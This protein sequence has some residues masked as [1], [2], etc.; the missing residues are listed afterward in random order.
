MRRA[1]L[2]AVVQLTCATAAVLLLVQGLPSAQD[3]T[4]SALKAAYIYNFA[5]FTE[6]PAGVVL[7]A[8]PLALCVLGDTN[9]GDALKRAVKDRELGGHSMAVSQ[10]AMG[11]TGPQPTCH[12]M[13]VSGVSA[14]QAAEVIARV[15]D[16]PVLTLSDVEGFTDRGGIA[17]FFFENGQL[18]FTVQLESIKRA[19]LRI[20]SR[21]LSLARRR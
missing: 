17:Q 10:P 9:V 12:V 15:R 18:R 13:Y 4:E 8:E 1:S 20:S 7:A 6:W 14:G 2:P 16:V 5:K 21:L 19:R 11:A 3:V